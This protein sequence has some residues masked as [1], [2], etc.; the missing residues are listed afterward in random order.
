MKTEDAGS[1]CSAP[2][3][4]SKVGTEGAVGLDERLTGELVLALA[5]QASNLRLC[6]TWPLISPDAALFCCLFCPL[7]LN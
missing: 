6:S 2:E 7:T 3:R 5:V 4:K 1:F